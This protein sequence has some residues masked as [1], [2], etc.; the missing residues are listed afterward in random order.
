MTADGTN[1]VSTMTQPSYDVL[2]VGGGG[3]G[4]AA[5]VTA[6]E[7][8]ARVLIVE[9][10]DHLGGS[11]ELAAGVFM[12]A[13]TP[14]QVELGYPEDSINGFFD[15]Y[16]TFNRWD[17]DPAT[18]RRFC[19]RAL[20][21]MQWLTSHGVSFPA[22]GVS[23]SGLEPVPLS[24]RP[25]GEGKAIVDALRSAAAV[26]GV[27]V[28][29]GH[30]V[31]TLV[32]Q[33]GRVCGVQ[34]N[35]EEVTGAAVILTTGGFG[36]NAALV[37]QHIPDALMGGGELWAPGAATDVGDGLALGE[38]VGAATGG[39]NHGDLLLTGGLINQLEPR[40]PGWLVF[41]NQQGRRFVN[42]LAPYH[43]ITPLTIANGGS[44]WA[45]F[46]DDACR[47]ARAT[48]DAWGAGTW[49]A[50]TLLAGADDGRVLRSPTVSE[51]A[52]LMKVPGALL[53]STFDRYNADYRAGV[54]THFLKEP[55]V[56]RPI[57]TAPF[58]ALKLRPSVVALTGYGLRIDADARVLGAA[59]DRPIPGLYAGGEV[60]GNV[61]GPQYLG[62][63][64][65]ISNALIFGRIAGQTAAA[66]KH[67]TSVSTSK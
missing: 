64:N 27:D 13:G 56:M 19:D 3:A 37:R 20:P 33:D 14:A 38:Q 45:V 40:V 7:A 62:N 57:E 17:T 32:V 25:V 48:S 49:T 24:H 22:I 51:L 61:I 30:R 31:Q 39:R 67:A 42:E 9:A 50:D 58:Y 21:T 52:D 10:G 16:M 12:A 26:L 53:Q 60:T 55:T 6:A 8:G 15:Y 46:D 11:T 66:D 65:A 36:Q 59:D 28:A 43:V 23:R 29:L 47:N 1:L 54:D 5:A 63:G 35:G 41:V 18:A 2:V 34:A 44:C 4:L